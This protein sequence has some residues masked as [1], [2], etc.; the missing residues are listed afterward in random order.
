MALK[1]RGHPGRR[2]LIIFMAAIT[3]GCVFPSCSPSLCPLCQSRL[4]EQRQPTWILRREG[5]DGV[6]SIFFVF[7]YLTVTAPKV[8]H[9]TTAVQSHRGTLAS[10]DVMTEQGAI[11]SLLCWYQ[12]RTMRHFILLHSAVLLSAGHTQPSIRASSTRTTPS[13]H[14]GQ[15]HGRL[16]KLAQCR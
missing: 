8:S 10:W 9:T 11:A 13:Q 5:L 2:F 3:P 14:A 16:L 6:Q 7:V 1:G 15:T 12:T 4:T